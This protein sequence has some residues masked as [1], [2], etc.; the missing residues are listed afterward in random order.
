MNYRTLG[1]TGLKVAEIGFGGAVLGISNYIEAWDPAG[2]AERRS[3]GEA[4]NRAL[5]LGLNYLD[6]APGY[7][8]GISEAI[9]GE[10][11]G[12]RRSEF[13]LAT[14]TG[15]R[16]A[17]GIVKSVEESLRRLRT[18]VIDVL[19]FH[20]GWY[21]PEE[22]DQIMDRGGLETYQRLKEQGKV[23][24]LGFTAEGP[25]GGVSRLIASGAFDVLQARYNLMY[26]HSCDFVNEAGIIREAKTREMGVVTMRSMTSGT[27]QKLMRRSFPQLADADLDSFLLNYNL[28]NPL[29]DVV[30][31]GMRRV[32]EVE[33]NVRLSDAVS[34]RLDLADLHHRTV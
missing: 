26:Q 30:L 19:Q 9:I 12:H 16:D 34:H 10:A 1:R 31:V 17:G 6:T 13:I 32:E 29:L 22:V 24:F 25:S 20:G 28:S 15:A 7:G 27:F 4:L 23:R 8:N 21:P 3:M 33:K 5:D 18:D 11:V 2:D 14:K